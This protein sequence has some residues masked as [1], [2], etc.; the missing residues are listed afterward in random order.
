MNSAEA[1]EKPTALHTEEQEQWTE[2]IQPRTSL[3]DLRLKEVWRYRDLVAMFVRRDFV[4]TYKQT[5]L[6]PIWFFVQPLL[7]SITYI[8]IFSRVANLST[9]GLPAMVFY[10][11]G[12][13][14]WNYFSDTLNKTAT[15]FRDNANVFGKVYFPR[16]TMPVSIVIS[17]LIRFSIQLSLFLAVWIFYL[18]KGGTSIEPNVYMALVPFLIVIMGLLS[19][20]FGMI[21]SALTT[22]YRDMI[23]L[24]AFGV[25][26]L[27]YATPVIYPVSS[28]PEKY[29]WIIMANPVS[30]IV[31]TF[32]YAFLG[33]GS[34]S[35]GSL[36]Y[37]VLFTTVILF[38]GIVVFNKVEKSFTDTV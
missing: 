11:A 35:W 32:R 2:I 23:M 24:L 30:S 1:L 12:I 26:L 6:G 18:V 34:F 29:R 9:D 13:T 15:V 37:S 33:S 36:L 10:L 5:I 22:K 25:Q 8:I 21:I 28:I 20:G 31:E 14:I 16:L 19:L 7:T 4:A 38:T 17:S 27:M 3:F